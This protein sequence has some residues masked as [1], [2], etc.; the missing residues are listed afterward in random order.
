MSNSYIRDLLINTYGN[1]CWLGGKVSHENPLTY[2]HIKPVRCG[3]R[4][5]MNNGALLSLQKHAEFNVLESIYPDLA[6]EI[7]FYFT[8]YHGTYPQGVY[9]RI[10]GIMQLVNTDK[11]IK[12]R[13]KKKISNYQKKLRKKRR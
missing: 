2:H 10:N 13:N 1:K 11:H 7:N 6:E 9:E 8:V 12:N 3:G 4:T 5:T